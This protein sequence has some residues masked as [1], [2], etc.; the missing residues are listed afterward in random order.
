MTPRAAHTS[1]Y[2]NETDSLYVFGGYDLNFIL[3]NME[4]YRFNTSKWEDE[5]GSILGILSID[6]YLLT[7]C[8]RLS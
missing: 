1:V 5:L 4:V 7:S 3:S 2:I 6:S 8:S